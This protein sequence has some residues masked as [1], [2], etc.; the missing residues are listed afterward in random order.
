MASKGRGGG[1]V[2]KGR[3]PTGSGAEEEGEEEE[4]HS[5]GYCRPRQEGSRVRGVRGVVLS[6]LLLLG[7]SHQTTGETFNTTRLEVVRHMKQKQFTACV[8]PLVPETVLAARM[9]VKSTAVNIYYDAGNVTVEGMRPNVWHEISL[10]YDTENYVHT[11]VATVD[12][13][14]IPFN[15]PDKKMWTSAYAFSYVDFLVKGTIEITG[16]PPPEDPTTTAAPTT[17]T[18][19]TTEASIHETPHGNV[20]YSMSTKP[21]TEIVTT[22]TDKTA[23]TTNNATSAITTTDTTMDIVTTAVTTDRVTVIASTDIAT[24]T[25][26]VPVYAVTRGQT[27]SPILKVTESP[28]LSHLE[29]QSTSPKAYDT[30]TTPDTGVITAGDGESWIWLIGSVGAVP[31]L[32]LVIGV[33]VLVIVIASIILVCCLKKRDTK[34]KKVND[35]ER[36]S[37]SLAENTMLLG[38][39]GFD[40][41]NAKN[42]AVP[43]DEVNGRSYPDSNMSSF[44]ESYQVADYHHNVG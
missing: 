17:T 29:N 14:T 15:K 27:P 44:K 21:Y 16:C 22:D 9:Y 31:A 6:F 1:P 34:A 8:R 2:I 38:P 30:N 40:E 26:E 32:P 35:K 42:L 20:S 7:F 39:Y 25:G 12:G 43:E 36:N 10:N 24:T 23:V 28:T 13:E 11:L 41:R 18:A 19:T 5:R 33:A 37:R 4:A 3:P